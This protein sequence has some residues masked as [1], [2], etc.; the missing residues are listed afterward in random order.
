VGLAG[1][2]T[3]VGLAKVDRRRAQQVTEGGD[4]GGGA[5]TSLRPDDRVRM[6]VPTQHRQRAIEAGRRA[7]Q[8]SDAE[9]HRSRTAGLTY[10]FDLVSLAPDFQGKDQVLAGRC[11]RPGPL[12][13]SVRAARQVGR[14][15]GGKGSTPTDEL[16]GLL[17]RWLIARSERCRRA[18]MSPSR[19]TLYPSSSMSL[20]LTL[21]SALRRLSCL[22]LETHGPSTPRSE[23]TQSCLPPGSG[24]TPRDAA[25]V[26]LVQGH[27]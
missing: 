25:L 2:A 8:A 24:A 15:Q 6:L 27:A 5:P 18:S 23:H 26:V 16:A 4:L 22:P 20:P 10:R 1:A 9:Q 11:L 13:G 3:R 19:G 12:G 7:G 17:L 21:R 14:S